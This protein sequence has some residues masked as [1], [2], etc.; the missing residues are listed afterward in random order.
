MHHETV[1]DSEFQ[2]IADSIQ[3]QKAFLSSRV[4]SCACERF[5]SFF[6]EMVQCV[7]LVLGFLPLVSHGVQLNRNLHELERN[8]LTVIC[9]SI[10][11]VSDNVLRDLG[12]DSMS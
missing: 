7:L 8:S 6:R 3:V 2:G 4:L 12:A 10:M 5:E 11:S 9:D 1:H